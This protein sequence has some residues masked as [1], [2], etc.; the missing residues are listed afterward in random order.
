MSEQCWSS[1]AGDVLARHG[2]AT[3][4]LDYIGAGAQSA[5]Y[6]TR[7]VAVLLSRAD[8]GEHVPGLTGHVLPGS[9]GEHTSCNTYSVLQWVTGRAAGAGVRTPRILAV[10]K[11]PRPYALIERAHG[12]I[13]S[14]HPRVAESA[15]AWFGQLGAEIRKTHLVETSGFGMFVPDGSGGYRGRFSTWTDYLNRWLAVHLCIGPARPEDQKV[16][17]LFLAQGIVTERD[18]ATVASKVREAQEW[19]VRSVLTHYDNRLDNLVVDAEDRITML[20]WGLSLAGIGISQELIKLFETEPLSMKSPRVSAFLH[21]YG[22]SEAE[23]V[24]AIEDGKLML[25]LE[26]IAMSYGWADDPD[27]LDGIR[28]WLRT[29]TRIC[30]T[31]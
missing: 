26:G 14:S 1:Q 30:R 31:W 7:E 5:C 8:V 24:K 29:V 3:T 15:A 22:L 16:L 20:D 23:C 9:S 2:Y 4:Q 19:P 25:V 17:D 10:G 18:F 13:A 6:G 28:A 12:T 21:S 27:R 11:H